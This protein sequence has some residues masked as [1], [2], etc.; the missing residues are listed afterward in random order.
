MMSSDQQ[1]A[2]PAGPAGEGP[3]AGASDAHARAPLVL[4]SASPRRARIL[5]E[6]GYACETV[7]ANAPET[8]DDA[9]PAGTVV[10]NALA[11][12][13]ACRAL[14]PGADLVTADTIVWFRGRV[15][16]KPRDLVE[17]AAFL[18]TLSGQAHTVFTAV[19]FSRAGDAAPSVR[20]EASVVRFRRLSDAEIAAYLDLV[21]PLDRAGAYDISDHGPLL[22]EATYGSDENIAGLPID[23]LR[24][25][26]D[27]RG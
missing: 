19:A 1:D 6:A 3:A 18:R 8:S 24:P 13:S 10:R 25:W 27:K 26:L 16:G 2:R 15:Y 12:H 7:A 17:A 14:R 21:H 4:G 22:I 20:V 9:D 5:R 11:K 23:L